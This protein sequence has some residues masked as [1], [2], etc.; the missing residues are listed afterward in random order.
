MDYCN[1]VENP[2]HRLD[3]PAVTDSE[4]DIYFWVH[5]YFSPIER[6]I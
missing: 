4:V 1:G 6:N 2:C 5:I 3:K